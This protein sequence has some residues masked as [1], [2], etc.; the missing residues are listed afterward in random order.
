MKHTKTPRK[1]QSENT[2]ASRSNIEANGQSHPKRLNWLERHVPNLLIGSGLVGL[3]AS[4]MLA[5]E[6]FHHLKHPTAP[7]NC[8]LNPVVSCGPA[9]DV[10]QGHALLGIP[11]QFLGIITFTVMLTIGMALLAGATFKRWFWLGLQA[12]MFA[13]LVFVHWFIYQSIYVLHHL[14]PYCMV[15]WVATITGFW[16]IFLYGL[17]AEHFKLRGNWRRA[18]LFVQQHHA[19]IL[20]LWFITIIGLILYHFWYY[21]STLLS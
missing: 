16:Y 17:R 2:Q 1:K 21:W 3:L 11:N 7:L 20:A 10:W 19:D 15:T 14:C 12:G 5:V 6:E 18:N 13:G 8:D 9:M 4:F